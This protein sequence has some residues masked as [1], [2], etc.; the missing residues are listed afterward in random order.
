[1]KF[2]VPRRR[3]SGQP[4]RNN[5]VPRI[6]STQM[7][8]ELAR[9]GYPQDQW[10]V[11][12]PLVADLIISY[13]F[14]L[15]QTFQMVQPDDLK[16]LG[17]QP[18]ELRAIAVDNI[19][20]QVRKIGTMEEPPVMRVWTGND[21]EACV[22]LADSYWRELAANTPGEIVASVPRRDVLLFCSSQSEEGLFAL[23]DIT[24]QVYESGEAHAL[25]KKLLV[26]RDGQWMPF[27]D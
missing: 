8:A 16:E 9:M 7:L 10:P 4:G 26:W 25:S 12:E 22:L 17:I 24:A 3:S 14:D 20:K 15:P 11:T 5:I 18:G 1:M 2:P 19:K 21:L 27:T 23:T 6:K 13:A